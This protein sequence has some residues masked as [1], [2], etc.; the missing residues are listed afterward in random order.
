MSKRDLGGSIVKAADSAKNIGIIVGI[1]VTMFGLY[2]GY[3][4]LVMSARTQKLSSFGTVKE[5]IKASEDQRVNI[6]EALLKKDAFPELLKQYGSAN[7]LLYESNE[8][9]VIGIIL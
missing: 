1:A 6:R 9:V 3:Q 2:K 5:L 7:G 8:D 4:E